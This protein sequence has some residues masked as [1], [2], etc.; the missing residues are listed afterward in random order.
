M[1]FV[2]IKDE[3]EAKNLR[4]YLKQSLQAEG[5]LWCCPADFV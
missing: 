2:G 1:P 5:G 3:V 4:D